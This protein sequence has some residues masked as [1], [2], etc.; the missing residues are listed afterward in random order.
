[1]VAIPKISLGKHTKKSFFDLSH[2]VNTTCDFGFCQPTLF[3]EVIPDTDINLGTRSLT[4]LGVMPTPSF[5][6]VSAKFFNTFVPMSEVFPAFDNMMSQIPYYTSFDGT[7]KYPDT[8]DY[9][10]ANQLLTYCLLNFG[11]QAKAFNRNV[12]AIPTVWLSDNNVLTPQDIDSKSTLY[13]IFASCTI[14]SNSSIDTLSEDDKSNLLSLSRT[15]YNLA[16]NYYQGQDISSSNKKYNYL[17]VSPD[18]ADFLCLSGNYYVSFHLT[19]QGKRLFKVLYGL[20][21]QFAHNRKVPL[22]SLLAYYK[23]WFDRFNPGRDMTWKATNAYSLIHAYYDRV[24]TMADHIAN[25]DGFDRTYFYPF[26]NEI[27]YCCYT[28]PI[29]AMSCALPNLNNGTYTA[30][31]KVRGTGDT[32]ALISPNPDGMYPTA[33]KFDDGQSIIV[34]SLLKLLPFVNKNSVIG[35]NIDKYMQTHFNQ[36][37][38]PDTYSF[39][40]FS[41]PLNIE[42][43]FSTSETDNSY[44]GEY[45]GKGVGSGSEE[46]SYHSKEFGFIVQLSCIVPISGYSQ[47]FGTSLHV[48]RD[49]FYNHD[50]ET[51]GL[52]AM[53]RSSIFGA[54]SVFIN[55][56][57][58][59]SAFGFR[60]RYFEYKYHPNLRNGGFQ[61]RSERSQL[62]PYMLDK[63]FNEVDVYFTTDETTGYPKRSGSQSS[64]SLPRVDESLRY[65]NQIESYGHYN[66]L[67]IDNSGNND[68]FIMHI[69]QDLKLH[70]PMLPITESFDTFDNDGVA[71][72]NTTVNINHA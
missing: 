41:Y 32:S 70:S 67:F 26:L 36:S 63:N 4:R 66:R 16:M 55:T 28:E 19:K 62:L 44:L 11:A 31:V 13:D 18:S 50:F 17:T 2:D 46:F 48:G 47:C 33:N 24:V 43:V 7:N 40:E 51:L 25:N 30:N 59:D 71:G 57:L 10:Y 65:I 15:G 35:K 54:S 58:S 14:F 34:K 23:A 9:V 69:V 61:N 68:N 42:P 45:G 27:I 38:F 37:V 29:D 5:A 60:P 52:D 21:V 64:V 20:G 1:M 53:L 6:R 3:Q 22:T 39:G 56:S 49:D 8:C 72:D 12:L